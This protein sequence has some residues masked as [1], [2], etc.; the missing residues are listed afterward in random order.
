MEYIN[1]VTNKECLNNF[2]VGVIFVYYIDGV[3][4]ENYDFSDMPLKKSQYYKKIA[5]NQ[6]Y[7][8]KGIAFF[9]VL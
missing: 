5:K 7:L 6:N 9:A 3:P 8:K 2:T 1:T 4:F